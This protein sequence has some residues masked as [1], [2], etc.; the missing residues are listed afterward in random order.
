MCHVSSSS[1]VA[2]KREG[3]LSKDVNETCLLS[4]ITV[5]E[6]RISDSCLDRKTDGA[7]G[8]KRMLYP[9]R[10]RRSGGKEEERERERERFCY[11]DSK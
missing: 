10:R 7:R 4:G 3:D 2:G 6:Y 11:S 5:I 8:L 9:R 1:T